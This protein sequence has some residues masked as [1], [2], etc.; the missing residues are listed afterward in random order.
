M[1]F[2]NKL[3]TVFTK[4]V[5]D[6]STTGTVDKTDMAK[7]TRTAILV[8]VAAGVSYVLTNVNPDVFGSY[9]PLITVAGAA[10]LDFLN[11]LTKGK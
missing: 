1:G 4:Q 10:L 2:F 6:T 3:K 5:D 8:A 7:V 9:G 11:K